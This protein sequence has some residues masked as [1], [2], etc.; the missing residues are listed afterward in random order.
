MSNGLRLSRKNL[1][2]QDLFRMIEDLEG[3]FSK[4]GH[5]EVVTKFEGKVRRVLLN[6]SRL[7]LMRYSQVGY[8][9]MLNSERI[10]N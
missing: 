10:F 7:S 9:S 4:L 8:Q 5:L 2:Y 6:F 1:S 3:L